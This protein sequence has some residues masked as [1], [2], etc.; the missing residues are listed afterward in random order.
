MSSD[1]TELPP[2]R[3]RVIRGDDGR[4]K[5][6]DTESGSSKTWSHIL[7]MG[8]RVLERTKWEPLAISMVLTALDTW[9]MEQEA[10]RIRRR[11][12]RKKRDENERL[13]AELREKQ[14]QEMFSAMLDIRDSLDIIATVYRGS[15]RDQ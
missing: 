12:V 8:H 6:E 2:P 11:L 3:F 10:K 14:R 13:C 15:S 5:V 4:R 9:L 7:T 1:D